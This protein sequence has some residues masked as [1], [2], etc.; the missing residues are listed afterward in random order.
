MKKIY[1][2]LSCLLIL[3]FSV[4]AQIP[5]GSFESWTGGNP[6]GWLTNNDGILLFTS[7]TS[8]FHD[9]TKA[10]NNICL[11][12]GDSI[13]APYIENDFPCACRP[14]SLHFWYIFNNPGSV[15]TL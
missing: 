4:T 13:L 5:D 11:A 15:D 2:P 14:T 9:G 6:T 10:C 3:C 1:L 8:N 7:S 12:S